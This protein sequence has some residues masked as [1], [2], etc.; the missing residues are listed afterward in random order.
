MLDQQYCTV[1][2][3]GHVRIVTLNRPHVMNA[4]FPEAH[5][6]LAAIWDD[7]AANDDLWVG[8]IT[9]AGDKAFCAG[10]DLKKQAIGQKVLPPAT[11]FAGLSRRFDLD[12]PLIAAVNGYALGGGFEIALACD[13]VIADETAVFALPE[14]RVGMIAAQ[15]G[16]HRLARSIPHKQALGLLLTGRRVSAAE[17]VQMGFVTEVAPRGEARSVAV[18]W[19]E[20][21]L[22]C[23]PKAVRATKQVFFSGMHRNLGEAIET[24]YPAQ[25]ENMN[26][27]D[28]LEGPRAFAEKRKPVWTNS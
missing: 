28:F 20:M 23:S 7:F 14:P 9:G 10:N 6:E 12:K 8:I 2:D 25:Q 3:D 17:A 16:I 18:K 27:R 5:H 4:L 19:A 24:V 11:G 26:S 13:V 15:G 1:Q 22:E 21:I